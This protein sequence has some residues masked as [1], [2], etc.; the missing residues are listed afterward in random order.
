MC[1]SSGLGKHLRSSP[2]SRKCLTLERAAEPRTPDAAHLPWRVM[3]GTAPL[4]PRKEDTGAEMIIH[5]YGPYSWVDDRGVDY[6]FTADIG[7]KAGLYLWTIK[8][9]GGELIYYVGETGRSFSTRMLEHFRAC[10][11]SCVMLH[12]YK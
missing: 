10:F 11:E 2:K 4:G 7:Q 5:F 8:L 6:I 9:A 12:L 3:P 1:V